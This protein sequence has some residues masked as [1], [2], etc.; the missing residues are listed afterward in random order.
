LSYQFPRH[1]RIYKTFDPVVSSTRTTLTYCLCWRDQRD[2]AL[3]HQ[4]QVLLL[5][6]Q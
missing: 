2:N 5:P 1:K 3:M 4:S 6:G